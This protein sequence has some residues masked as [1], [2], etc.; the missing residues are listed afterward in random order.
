MEAPQTPGTADKLA[1]NLRKGVLESCVLALLAGR[2]MYGLELA[3]ELATRDLSAGAGSLY[4][5]LGR[6]RDSGLVVTRWD[7][8]A[9]TRARRYYA[10]TPAGREHLAQFARVWHTIAPEVE[11]LL[12]Q[13]PDHTLDAPAPQE[14]S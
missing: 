7:T 10:I 1:S 8:E 4:P 3:D 13:D 11:Q 9:S 12:D 2:E 14:E 5:L 6:M